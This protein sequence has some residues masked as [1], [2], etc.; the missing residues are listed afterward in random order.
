M[1]FDTPLFEQAIL[2]RALAAGLELP[3][4]AV[5]ALA[6]H[7][8]AVIDANPRLH[9]T[10]IVTPREFV[11][12]HLGESFAGAALLDRA[13]EGPLLDLGSGNG[14]P[15]IPLAASRRGLLPCLAEASAKKAAFL[16]E[17][18]TE[19]GWSRGSVLEVAVR[20]PREIAAI[21][22]VRILATRAMGHWEKLV[23]KLVPSLAAD[24]TVLI[25][26]GDAVGEVA[27]RVAWRRLKLEGRHP[28]PGRTRSWIWVFR[29][30]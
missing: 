20:G 8:R 25:W 27:R 15:G 10:A 1:N 22:P 18:L 4:D 3:A 6:R 30:A 17:L 16:R 24:A 26:A 7:A 21:G 19:L 2:G 28:L 12:R 11:E 9:L 5:E 23:P 29:P 14:Y 13:I